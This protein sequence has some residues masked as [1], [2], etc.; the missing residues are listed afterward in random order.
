MCKAQRGI[1]FSG[2]GVPPERGTCHLGVAGG[3]GIGDRFKVM[4]TGVVF[5]MVRR[6]KSVSVFDLG[7]RSRWGFEMCMECT[8]KRFSKHLRAVS[9][10][11]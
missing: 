2:E 8:P 4:R 1:F 9:A 10:L 3:E 7:S 11:R 5:P 6:E